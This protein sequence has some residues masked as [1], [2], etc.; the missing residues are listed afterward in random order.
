MESKVARANEERDEF[1]TKFEKVKKDM[2]ALK[3]QID[4]EKEMALT[5]Q[6]EELESIKKQIRLQA[7]QD[8]E[9]QEFNALK[10]QLASL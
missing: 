1:K 3:K 4:K 2:I 10:G 6:A 9:R 5:K 8:Q 7:Q